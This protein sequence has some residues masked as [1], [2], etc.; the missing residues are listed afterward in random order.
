MLKK[1]PWDKI[2]G[3][4]NVLIFLLRIPAY[5]SFTFSLR[6]L[7]ELKDKNLLPKTVRGIFGFR[8]RLVFIKAYIFAEE[9]A[10][11]L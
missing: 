6:F 1:F 3:T 7:Y 5:H 10:W 11:T 2:N 9:N 8:F 4:K